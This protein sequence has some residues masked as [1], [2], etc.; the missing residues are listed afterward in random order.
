MARTKP[1]WDFIT[2][3]AT[4][5]ANLS[6]KDTA[7]FHCF[8]PNGL[9]AKLKA[10]HARVSQWCADHPDRPNGVL[11]VH[12]S[13]ND[14]PRKR[15]FELLE[16]KRITSMEVKCAVDWVRDDIAEAELWLSDESKWPEKKQVDA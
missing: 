9:Y 3:E 15:L 14:Y 10:V 1:T 6:A 4:T 16:R 12:G 8:N 11:L 2:A 5:D 13:L 7:S